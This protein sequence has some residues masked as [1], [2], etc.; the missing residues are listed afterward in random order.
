[1]ILNGMKSTNGDGPAMCFYDDL[2][3]G[4]AVCLDLNGIPK[5][6]IQAFPQD[7]EMPTCKDLQ[8]K[9]SCFVENIV[10]ILS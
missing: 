3:L 8:E 9:Q 6:C 4:L 5:L 1:M 2:V 10:V 7:L